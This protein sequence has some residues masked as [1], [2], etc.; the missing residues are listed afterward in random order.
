[1]FLLHFFLLRQHRASKMCPDILAFYR[2][3]LLLFV[4]ESYIKASIHAKT[5]L[6]LRWKQVA[7]KEPCCPIRLKTLLAQVQILL[8]FRLQ[9]FTNSVHDMQPFICLCNCTLAPSVST[10]F[11]FLFDIMLNYK[12]ATVTIWANILLKNDCLKK[13]LAKRKKWVCIPICLKTLQAR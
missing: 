7:S 11:L 9:N 1:M 4:E 2:T 5:G 12:F 8:A 10:I 3:N 6:K 13:G